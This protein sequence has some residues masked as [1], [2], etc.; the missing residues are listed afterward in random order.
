MYVQ[1]NNKAHLCHYCCSGKA[2]GITQPVCVF[3]ALGMQNAIHICH[4]VN[5]GLP[6]S[7]I[8]FNTMS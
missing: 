3:V 2:M 1:R 6:R 8:F 4:I 5:G 7:T